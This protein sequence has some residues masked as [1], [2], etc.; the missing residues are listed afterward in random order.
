MR[1]IALLFAGLVAYLAHMTGDPV[2][3]F[4]GGIVVGMTFKEVMSDIH[5]ERMQKQQLD[6]QGK[7][8]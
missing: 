7:E 4:I 8:K 3:T 5:F 6:A 2:G 1:I